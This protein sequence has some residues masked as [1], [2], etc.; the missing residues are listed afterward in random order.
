MESATGGLPLEA[1]CGADVRIWARQGS[2]LASVPGSGLFTS[3]TAG[4]TWSSV[5]SDEDA[6]SARTFAA[7]PTT[8]GT[9]WIGTDAG[10]FRTVDGGVSFEPVGQPGGVKS[11]SVDT[12]NA[13]RVAM[14]A[15]AG[16]G[17][18]VFRLDDD[19][20]TWA[21]V[22]PAGIGV[23]GQV[24]LL[25]ATEAILGTSTGV[26]VSTDGGVTWTHAY[27]GGA[28]MGEP[29]RANGTVSW[30]LSGGR[31]VVQRSPGSTTWNPVTGVAVIA[32]TSSTLA[33]LPDGR[34]VTVGLASHLVVQQ[35]IG[36]TAWSPFDPAPPYRPASIV[37]SGSAT[38]VWTSDCAMG[39][40]ATAVDSILRLNDS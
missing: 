37:R 32:P 3:T 35:A 31:G 7:H 26:F 18:R 20:T 1:M 12:S 5:G 25:S 40:D 27:T 22:S 38:L 24:V 13:A 10:V 11:L 16:N 4:T 15:V 9:F 36:G 29:V 34:L 28:V 39:N 33:A 19:G 30:L 23:G 17:S 21:D 8:A 14:L 6:R 2:L